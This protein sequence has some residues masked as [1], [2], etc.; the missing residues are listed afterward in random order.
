MVQYLKK[1][2]NLCNIF[3]QTD[4]QRIS[5]VKYILKGKKLGCQENYNALKDESCFKILPF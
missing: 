3:F 4:S 5:T 1:W 2:A